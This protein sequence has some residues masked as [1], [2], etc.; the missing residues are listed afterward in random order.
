M[1]AVVGM[2]TFTA[3]LTGFMTYTGGSLR[4]PPRDP[5]ADRMAEK[6]A[7]RKLRRRPVEET[8]AELG[9]GRGI[10]GPG[11]AERR[12]QRIKENYGIEVPS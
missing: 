1:P 3:V 2:G 4:G 5:E 10:Y 8:I 7:I 11:Y 9:E 12:R 6:A